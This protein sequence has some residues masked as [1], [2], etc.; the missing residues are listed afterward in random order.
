MSLNGII[1]SL[2]KMVR[3]NEKLRLSH[4]KCNIKYFALVYI[5]F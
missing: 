3:E 4:E 5:M 1:E 2:D